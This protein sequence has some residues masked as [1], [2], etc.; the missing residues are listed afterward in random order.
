MTTMKTRIGAIALDCSDPQALAAFYAELLGTTVGFSTDT[1][2]AFKTGGLWFTTHKVDEYRP[3][4]WPDPAQPQQAHLDIAVDGDDL[5]AAEAHALLAGATKSKHQPQ[6]DA[7]RVMLD[8]AGH[9][10]CLSPASA[11]PD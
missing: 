1:F 11:F 7:W 2:A 9:P 5:D 8:P 4:Q 3:P 10:F 6:R